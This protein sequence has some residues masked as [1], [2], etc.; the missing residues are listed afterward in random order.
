MT[1]SYSQKPSIWFWIISVIA[2]LWNAVGVFQYLIKA[3]NTEGF[4]SQYTA[5]QLEVIA[6]SPAWATAAFAIGVFGGLI[7]SGFLL[8]RLKLA[9]IF[10]IFSL[11]GIFVQVYHNHF[12]IDSSE[13]MGNS[14]AYFSG[15]IVVIALL[16]LYFS[17]FA[18]KKQ[19]IR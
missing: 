19:W 3:Y 2:L 12:V 7:A 5:E 4:R 13:I 9:T 18:T 15:T 10:Y 1:D 11:L 16:L 17:I 8:M 14:A 6:N